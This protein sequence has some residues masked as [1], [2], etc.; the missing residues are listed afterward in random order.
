MPKISGE[1]NLEKRHPK[2]L[3]CLVTKGWSELFLPRREYLPVN[4]RSKQSHYFAF[5]TY[6]F[7]SLPEWEP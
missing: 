1:K 7:V 4:M 2:D 3:D 5:I 6:D